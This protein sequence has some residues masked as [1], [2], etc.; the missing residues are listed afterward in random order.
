MMQNVGAGPVTILSLG[1]SQPN[2]KQISLFYIYWTVGGA[3]AQKLPDTPLKL[4]R[5]TTGIFVQ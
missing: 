4:V 5:P 3:V 1:S 2:I